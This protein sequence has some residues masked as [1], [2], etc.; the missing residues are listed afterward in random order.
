MNQWLTAAGLLDIAAGDPIGLVVATSCDYFEPLAFPGDVEVGLATD[1]LG[2]SS[3]TYRLGVFPAG[4]QRAAAE[5][6]FTHVCASR[7]G[8][9]PVP[10]PDHWRE[11][12]AALA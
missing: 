8:R 2:R 11:A 12:L 10:L 1:R 4:G 9:S 5:G 7:A 3:V 6:R